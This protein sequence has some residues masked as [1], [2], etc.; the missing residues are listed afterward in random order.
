M[1]QVP[2]KAA[3][4][5]RRSGRAMLSAHSIVFGMIQ[6]GESSPA[7][8]DPAVLQFHMAHQAE[9]LYLKSYGP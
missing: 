6:Q 9:L 2:T 8:S 7:I 4:N 3:L 5:S 1:T